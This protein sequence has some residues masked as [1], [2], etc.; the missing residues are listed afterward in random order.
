MN[1]KLSAISS[2]YENIRSVGLVRSKADFSSQW[3]GQGG[4][5][6]TSMQAR[7]RQPSDEVVAALASRLSHA[8]MRQLDAGAS[9]HDDRNR[10]IALGAALV[11]IHACST[12]Y[13]N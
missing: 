7:S 1:Q 8:A 13:S 12:S 9:N 3:L 4:S 2:V 11:S 6:L 5:Y 10:L